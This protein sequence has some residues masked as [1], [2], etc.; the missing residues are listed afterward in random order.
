MARDRASRPGA[1]ALRLFVAIEIP[2]PLRR[3]VAEAVEPVRERFPRARWVPPENQ[4]V[5]V[6]FLG[7][8]W[9]RLMGWVSEVVERVA[10]EA[11]P[12][13]SRVAGLGAFPSA[14]RARVLWA[15]L[16][17]AGE[18]SRLATALDERLAPEFAPEQRAFTP[19]LTVARFEPPVRL[20]G[21]E[22]DLRSEP[23]RVDHL[24][25]FQSRLRRPAPVYEPLDRFPFGGR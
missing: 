23:F 1:K 22:G 14:P 17:D 9:P 13:D 3:L 6:K 24:V 15:G 11:E 25:L 7:S 12:F 16:D 21:L 5:T 8:T 10:S 18:M 20:D 4:H 19:H 2:E